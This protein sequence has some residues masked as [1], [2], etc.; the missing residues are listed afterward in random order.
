MQT[1]KARQKHEAAE[2]EGEIELM[3]AKMDEFEK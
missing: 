2:E 3:Q 1:L